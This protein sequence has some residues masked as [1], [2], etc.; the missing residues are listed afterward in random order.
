LTLGSLRDTLWTLILAARDGGICYMEFY[1]KGGIFKM[2]VQLIYEK[3]YETKCQYNN[4][5]L[6]AKFKIDLKSGSK[7]VCERHLLEMRKTFPNLKKKSKVLQ[8][9][10]LRNGFVKDGVNLFKTKSIINPLNS[11]WARFRFKKLTE[12]QKIK[13]SFDLFTCYYI[14][15]TNTENRIIM[16][17]PWK[18]YIFILDK[19]TGRRII[20]SR[21]GIARAEINESYK[22]IRYF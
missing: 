14:F 8:E 17:F 12:S 9:I 13:K 11:K 3:I 10:K 16:E 4:C 5:N 19:R 21:D 15:I 1:K 2:E 7:F 18:G 6:P 20:F 22:V